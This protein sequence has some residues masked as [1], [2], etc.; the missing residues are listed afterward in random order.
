MTCYGNHNLPY[1]VRYRQLHYMLSLHLSKRFDQLKIWKQDFLGDGASFESKTPFWEIRPCTFYSY[2]YYTIILIFCLFVCLQAPIQ[3]LADR[4]AGVFVPGIVTISIIT[5]L[6]HAINGYV[7]GM[8]HP[9]F[10]V[11]VSNKQNM[12]DYVSLYQ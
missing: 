4:I 5:L 12:S 10:H 9:P 8:T 7:S 2:I 11:H 3:K 6:S 1:T